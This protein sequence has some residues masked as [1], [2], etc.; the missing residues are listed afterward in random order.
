MDNPWQICR[1]IGP[2]TLHRHEILHLSGDATD[3]IQS[4]PK[5]THN[6]FLVVLLPAWTRGV[7][8][9]HFTLLLM[10]MVVLSLSFIKEIKV[11][12]ELFRKEYQYV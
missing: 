2:L 6:D 12:S 8:F 9:L 3:A 1:T 5:V 4:W 7:T 10:K 11:V